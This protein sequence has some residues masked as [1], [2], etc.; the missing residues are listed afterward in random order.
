MGVEPF[1][2]ASSLVGVV[3]QRLLRV[4][5][6]RCKKPYTLSRE[7]ILKSIPD[8]P[9]EEGEEEITLYKSKGCLACNGAGYKGRMGIYEFL[10]VG[11]DMQK[12]ILSRASTNDIREL[13]IKE[14]METLRGDGL[15]KVKN[16]VT[17]IEELLRVVV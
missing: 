11:E 10:S 6:P 17:S 14:G 9:L 12:L 7:E 5:C 2:T 8:F 4:L 15:I 13:A 3:A 16:S 1:L